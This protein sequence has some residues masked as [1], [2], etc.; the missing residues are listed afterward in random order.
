M[1]PIS[2]SVLCMRLLGQERLSR[3][4]SQRTVRAWLR[5]AI[6]EA[7]RWQSGGDGKVYGVFRFPGHHIPQ[8]GE[9][10]THLAVDL[11]QSALRP[12]K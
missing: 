9:V 3:Q 11:M 7:F 1:T 5:L 8:A 12:C 4:T 6:M 2:T 10:S